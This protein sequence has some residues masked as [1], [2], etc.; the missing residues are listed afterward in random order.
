MISWG[1]W[2]QRSVAGSACVAV[3]AL[4]GCS[5]SHVVPA[6]SAATP[7]ATVPSPG[8]A[9]G[10][11]VAASSSS[12]PA[13][14]VAPLTGLAVTG[15][16]ARRAAVAIAVAGPDP[17][18]LQQADL[19]F[20]ERT[21]PVRYLAVFQSLEASKV[22][23]VTSTRPTDGQELSVLHP[24]ASYNGGGV[25]FIAVLDA[26]KVIDEGYAGHA[27]LYRPGP[28][29]L[30][31]SPAALA[32]GRP[33]GPPPGLF[34]YR[35]PGTSLASGR[36]TYPT[37]LRIEITGQRTERWTYSP[38]SSRWVQTAGG[39]PVRVA[40]L[41]VQI[42][43]F[44]TVYVSHRYNQTTRSARVIG[45]G[46]ATVFS[47]SAAGG[48]A[49]T[50]AAGTWSKPGLAAVTNYFDKAHLPMNFEPGPTW[51]VLAPAGTRVV[52]AGR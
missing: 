19:I 45:K 27:S 12:G 28:H 34:L 35:A 6:S 50:A 4:A 49:G 51:V 20:E 18:G 11:A 37:S 7:V 39:P 9:T 15:A 26:T 42:V 41:V 5:G 47:G 32:V 33:D 30:T 2:A 14:H 46:R 48:S 8:G 36:E 40:N 23:P 25:G 16:S 38:S 29:G 17:I 44:K 31:V 24:L 21:T 43:P 13:A 22:G 52:Q 3:S 1:G 10:P